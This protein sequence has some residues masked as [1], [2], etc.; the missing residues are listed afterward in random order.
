[1]TAAKDYQNQILAKASEDDEFRANLLND[2]AAT[3]AAE[4]NVNLPEG[5]DIQVHEDDQNVVNLV[6]PPKMKL[7]DS[8]L[9]R[10]SGGVNFTPTDDAGSW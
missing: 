1:M 10:V 8:E 3:V 7:G 5:L 4:L 2:P 6:L 9:D